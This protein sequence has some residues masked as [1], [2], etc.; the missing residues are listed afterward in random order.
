MGPTEDEPEGIDVRVADTEEIR[1]LGAFLA[2][3]DDVPFHPMFLTGHRHQLDTA[4]QTE[5]E[6]TTLCLQQSLAGEGL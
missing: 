4:E 2:T 1:L 6:E 3:H 5:L